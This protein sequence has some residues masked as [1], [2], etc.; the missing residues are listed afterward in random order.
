MKAA[1]RLGG[2]LFRYSQ[3]TQGSPTVQ[4]AGTP[5]HSPPPKRPWA[6]RPRQDGR[7]LC[8]ELAN[9][10]KSAPIWRYPRQMCANYADTWQ[11]LREMYVSSPFEGLLGAHS[12]ENSPD[13]AVFPARSHRNAHSEKS[14][15]NVESEA[16][17][18]KQRAGNKERGLENRLRTI[19]A[20]AS[21]R[22]AYYGIAPARA[23]GR[24]S[25]GL[26]PLKNIPGIRDSWRCQ[27][28]GNCPARWFPQTFAPLSH[29]FKI[30]PLRFRHGHLRRTYNLFTLPS[31]PLG[32]WQGTPIPCASPI[33][34]K[35]KREQ[36]GLGQG[37]A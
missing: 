13:R 10:Q 7:T 2:G 36:S 11:I 9:Y 15:P 5:K 6:L 30:R 26:P 35:A 25:D 34:R 19:P 18:D 24:G 32:G 4:T 37:T 14:S 29:L 21:S 23:R 1:S 31:I 12:R 33:R 22:L 27:P 16:G 17:Q 3:R 8:A 20:D 28:S